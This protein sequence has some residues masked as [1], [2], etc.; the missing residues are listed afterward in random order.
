MMRRI[1]VRAAVGARLAQSWGEYPVEL[2]ADEYPV[3]HQIPALRGHSLVVVT[4]A[5]QAVLDGAVGRHV[6]NRRPVAHDA[7]LVGGGER[8]SGVGRLV[9]DRAVVF[10]CVADGFV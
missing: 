9:A 3:A 4:D 2:V 7:E 6:H 5:G 10:G 1:G 8:G